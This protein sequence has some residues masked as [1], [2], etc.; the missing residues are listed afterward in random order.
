MTNELQEARYAEWQVLITE[1]SKSG[2]SKKNF[3]LQKNINLSKFIYYWHRL[4]KKSKPIDSSFTPVKVIHKENTVLNDI[5][6]GLPNGFQVSFSSH[7]ES[8]K[9]K[10]LIEA[11]LSC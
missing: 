4:N 8:S 3:C 9:I 6:V 1:Q 5:R 7:L 10:Q 11:L 2:L